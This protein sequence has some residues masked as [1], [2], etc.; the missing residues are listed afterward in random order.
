MSGR[1]LKTL[2]KSRAQT[3]DNGT[4]DLRAFGSLSDTKTKVPIDYVAYAA[5]R[6]GVMR[7]MYRMQYRFKKAT[8][9]GQRL[10]YSLKIKQLKVIA[11]DLQTAIGGR[12]AKL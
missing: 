11:F 12:G 3:V 10:S 8:S 5:S 2:V 1:L 4:V 9:E 7:A 6:D